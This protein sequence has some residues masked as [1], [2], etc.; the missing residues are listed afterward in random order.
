MRLD[1]LKYKLFTSVRFQ[2]GVELTV[3]A[4]IVFHEYG[5]ARV[6]T[7]HRDPHLIQE[8]CSPK[9]H[10]HRN[11]VNMAH[12]QDRQ[13][14]LS[15]K[16]ARMSHNAVF[17]LSNGKLIPR[18]IHSSTTTAAIVLVLLLLLRPDCCY[19]SYYWSLQC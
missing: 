16:Q 2:L 14:L 13:A 7:L 12:A 9:T 1:L 8:P 3:V 19:Y 11:N 5:H 15:F 4:G 18:S 6:D 17:K 10:I